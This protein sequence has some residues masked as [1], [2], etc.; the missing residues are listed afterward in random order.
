MTASSSNV[1]SRVRCYC[2]DTTDAR[3][4]DQGLSWIELDREARRVSFIG[5]NNREIETHDT[6]A[7]ASAAFDALVARQRERGWAVVDDEVAAHEALSARE[8]E[9]EQ[10]IRDAPDD[11]QLREVYADWLQQ[12]GDVRGELMALQIA[13]GQARR[14][15]PEQSLGLAERALLSRHGGHLLG[16][17]AWS[18]RL[19]EV[20]LS[21]ARGFV[22]EAAL[23]L[24]VHDPKAVAHLLRALFALPV[25]MLLERVSVSSDRDSAAF[26]DGLRGARLPESVESLRVGDGR[27]VTERSGHVDA[28]EVWHQLT[29]LQRLSV[30]CGDFV[31]PEG[32]GLSRLR[33]L[34][35]RAR[36]LGSGAMARLSRLSM[37]ALELLELRCG[38][39]AYDPFWRRRYRAYYWDYYG[40]DDIDRP[41]LAADEI[42]QLLFARG[43]GALRRLELSELSCGD[44]L[45]E[46]LAGAPL[47][48]QLE[49][50]VLRDVAMTDEGARRIAENRDAFEHLY[51]LHL[52]RNVIGRR[53]ERMLRRA[54]GDRAIV[55]LQREQG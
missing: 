46:R 7:A 50:L 1:P 27:D 33:E 32:A 4:G 19:S 39:A 52:E 47:L 6:A 54:L 37:P 18:E 22:I 41:G 38:T 13:R 28:S 40:D 25:C 34:S 26:F 14:G 3:R 53:G 23:R 36:R 29:A 9:L 17:V 45:A 51:A 11:D 5:P 24:A 48:A 8:P 16:D 43:Y 42:V 49:V 10:A 31:V 12:Q 21:W 30:S 2:V 20:E 35:V 55:G 15:N 44:D